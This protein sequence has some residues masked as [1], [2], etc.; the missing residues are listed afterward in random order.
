MGRFC[1]FLAGIAAV[2]LVAGCLVG[3][4]AHAAPAATTKQVRCEVSSGREPQRAT[5]EQAGFD[6]ELLDA[7]L[8]FVTARNRFN[9]QVFRHNC[10][11]GEGL[12]NAKSG[13]VAWNIWSGTKSVVSLIA[14]IAWDR[15]LLDLDAPIDKYLPAGLGDPAHRAIRVEDLLTE[16]SGMTVGVLTEGITGV[17]PIDP[18][19]A[20]QALG[21]PLDNPPG[22]AFSYSQRN[23]DLL[24]FVIELAV[25]EPFQQFAQRELFGPLGIPRGDYYWAKDRA[26]NTYGYAHLMIPP[27]DFAKLGLL[28]SNQGRWGAEQLVSQRYMSMAL[29]PSQAN[30]CYGYLFWL[31]PGCAEAAP[32]LPRDMYMMAG[33]G[34]Q[35]VFVFPSLDLMVMWT[36][37]FGNVSKYGVS[38]IVQN[39]AELPHEFFRRLFAAMPDNPYP[40]PGPYVEPP[41][42]LDPRRFVDANLLL[43]VFGI[44]PAAYPG[45]NVVACLNYQLTP[46]FADIAPGCFVLVCVGHDPRTPRIR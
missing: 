43:A 36:G 37:V 24:T 13:R 17:V 22:T 8:E 1:G 12:N 45:C 29:T 2:S 25:G 40:D 33:L 35:N 3:A 11:V 41:I 14:G 27:D 6:A 15:G 39:T 16:T 30:H 18:H 34:L 31:G 44:G 9:V 21:V 32:S 7:A 5:P 46:P 26:G 42:R 20:V 28:V 19:S 10:L 38:G 23:V 4:T